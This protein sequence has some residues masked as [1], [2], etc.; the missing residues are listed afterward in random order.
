MPKLDLEIE[1]VKAS[2]LES[3]RSKSVRHS[4]L[5]GSKLRLAGGNSAVVRVETTKWLAKRVQHTR[6][7]S[8]LETNKDRTSRQIRIYWS[9]R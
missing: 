2:E 8:G 1:D 9:P 5:E 7:R 6:S 4:C 3:V